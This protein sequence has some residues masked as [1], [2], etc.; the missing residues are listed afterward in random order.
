MET[1]T[2]VSGMGYDIVGVGHAACDFLGIVPRM[3]ELDRCAWMNCLE[4]Q[5]GGAVSQALV[6]ASRLGA[7][8]AYAGFLGD[9]DAGRFLRDDFLKERVDIECLELLPQQRSSVAF[10]VIEQ[11]T[12]K[13]T[14]YVYPGTIASR[15]LSP[16]AQRLIAAARYLHLDATNPEAALEA[17]RFAKANQVQVSLDGC[18]IAKEKEQTLELI[19]LTDILIANEIYPR[20]VTGSDDPQKALL[21]LAKMGPEIVISTIGKDGCLAVVNSEIVAFTA[22]SV[23]VVDTTGAGDVFHGA[24]LFGLLQN[25]PFDSIVRFASA[26]S[27][28]NCLS[29]GGR[30]GIP[31]QDQVLRF[32]A[33]YREQSG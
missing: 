5:G 2:E 10:V 22:Y 25:W 27:A 4:R 6:A 29:L 9:D 19:R 11:G 16:K 33:D 12:G 15:P 23:P 20:E 32:I 28:I 14:I 3:P 24:F 21:E 26:T 8:V 7:R 30:A 1:D 17:A 31:T 18:E 13:R